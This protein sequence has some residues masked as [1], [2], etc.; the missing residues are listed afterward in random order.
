MAFNRGKLEEEIWEKIFEMEPELYKNFKIK[1]T[2]KWKD[3]LK[4]LRKKVE[5]LGSDYEYLYMEI[6]R[7][8][9]PLLKD[10]NIIIN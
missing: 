4:E 10:E 7:L 6:D 2:A 3:S 5:I 9:D 1:D 8:E